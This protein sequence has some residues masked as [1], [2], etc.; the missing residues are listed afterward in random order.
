MRNRVRECEEHICLTQNR[1]KS[2]LEI[3]ELFQWRSV[4]VIKFFRRKLASALSTERDRTEVK[5]A[6]IPNDL[7]QESQQESE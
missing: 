7:P 2:F 1:P 5:A 4:L 3:N 6:T